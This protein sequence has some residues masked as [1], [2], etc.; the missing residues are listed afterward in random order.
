M[1][2]WFDILNKFLIA[3][4]AKKNIEN[5]IYDLELNRDNLKLSEFHVAIKFDV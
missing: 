1:I 5:K 2:V 4:D 3:S